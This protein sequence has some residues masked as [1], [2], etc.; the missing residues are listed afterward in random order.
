MDERQAAAAVEEMV[1]RRVLQVVGDRLEFTHDRIR[2][3]AYDRLLPPRRR[4]LHRAVA[5]ALEAHP[6]GAVVGPTAGDAA[7]EPIEQLAHHALRGEL[8]QKSADCLRQAGLKAAAR[9]ALHDARLW[10]EQALGALDH[11]PETPPFL[12]HAFEIRIELRPVLTQLG[13]VRAA[14]ERL[15]EAGVLAERLGDE[16]RL[17]RVC[18][19]EAVPVM[20]PPGWPRLAASPS[21]IGSPTLLMIL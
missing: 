20:L 21:P 10:F 2:D 19:F 3:V 16:R 7:G 14:L 8:W 5:E 13:E 15:R 1:R 4:L 11:L 12:E 17:G 9:S 18:A 6:A